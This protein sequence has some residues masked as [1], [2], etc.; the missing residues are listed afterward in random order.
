MTGKQTRRDCT[1]SNEVMILVVLALGFFT[2]LP[3]RM[4]YKACRRLRRGE[5]SPA[6]SS[7]CMAR[8]RLGSEPVEALHQLAVRPLATPETPG[9][10]FRGLRK[11][12]LVELGTHVE[13]AFVFGGWKDHEKNL[14]KQL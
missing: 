10:F 14:A 8:Q 1:L 12:S 4:V 13:F 6:R 2:E 5:S 11:V 9:E 7:L 3:I